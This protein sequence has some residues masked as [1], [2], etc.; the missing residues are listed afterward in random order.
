VGVRTV[1][2]YAPVAQPVATSTGGLGQVLLNLLL[3]AADAVDGRSD[4]TIT[5][6]L[7]EEKGVLHKPLRH[8]DLV[9]AV[10]EALHQA[11]LSG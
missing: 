3:N 8:D 7:S 2:H 9:R 10:R 11:R 4:G 6:T 5:I 1:V